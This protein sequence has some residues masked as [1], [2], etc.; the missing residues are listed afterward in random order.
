MEDAAAKVVAEPLTHPA[1]KE[2]KA[3]KKFKGRAGKTKR[4]KREP[5]TYPGRTLED[6]VKVVEAI[7]TQNAGNPWPPDE[8][9]KAIKIK[10]RSSTSPKS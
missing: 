2:R 3:R 9:A 6:C 8:I 1:G 4:Q 7:K 5:R 10:S